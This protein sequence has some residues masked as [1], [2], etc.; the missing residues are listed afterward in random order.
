MKKLVALFVLVLAF[1]GCADEVTTNTP[2]FQ[3]HK[4]DALFRGIDVRAYLSSTGQVRLVALSQNETVTLNMSSI[5]PGYYYPGGIDEDNSAEYTST[6]E[7]VQTYLTYDANGQIPYINNPI[8]T[9]GTGYT[10]STFVSTTSLGGGTGM[11]VN[12]TVSPSGAVTAVEI[13]DPGYGYDP[14]D[15]ITVNGGGNNA[16]FKILSAIE[17]TDNSNGML[18]GNFR[19]TAKNVDPSS[20]FNELVSFQYGTF[21][22]IPIIPEP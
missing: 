20:P 5:N 13:A 18:T 19:F 10:E 11:K 16:R 22:Q 9:G 14:G 21:Y 12:T 8:L 6:F 15:V 17:I 7:D 1:A 3:A 2:G 4:D